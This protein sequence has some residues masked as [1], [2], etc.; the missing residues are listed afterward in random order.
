MTLCVF[1]GPTVSAAE[2]REVLPALC[3]PPVRQGDIY[4]TTERLAPTALG[5][6]DG[7][8]HEVP[9]VWHKEILWAM[10]RGVRVFGAASMGALRAAELADFGMRGVGRIFEAY[11]TG[12]FS[13]YGGECFED[14]DEVAVLHGPPASGYAAFSE[15]MVNIR[16]TLAAAAAAGVVREQTRDALV[17]RAKG[18]YYPERSWERLLA[19]GAGVAVP[20]EELQALAAW[21]PH[22]RVD[23]K[24]ADA[25]AMLAAMR[26]PAVAAPPVTFQFACT[27]MWARLTDET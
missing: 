21:L 4:R 1:S 10:Q 6:I 11:R 14:D 19:P 13:P 17:A 16:A 5:I 26:E 9:S 25:L 18:Q 12:R 23:Q 3:M 15:A 7:Y 2:V 27:T 24:R 20:D 22:G 8:F